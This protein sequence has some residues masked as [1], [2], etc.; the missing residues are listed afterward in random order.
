MPQ[1]ML[2][3]SLL[4][5]AGVNFVDVLSKSGQWGAIRLVYN[6]PPITTEQIFHPEKY[7]TGEAP[8]PVDLPNLAPALGQ[9]WVEINNGVL[10]E[11]FLR[12][13]LG[14]FAGLGLDNA[15]TGWGGDRFSLLEGPEEDRTFTA[16]I[17]WDSDR[18]A[19]E[20]YEFV[21]SNSMDSEDVFFRKK[22]EQVLW[23]VGKPP[24]ILKIRSQF[25]DFEQ[26][27]SGL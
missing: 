9:G 14:E 24:L 12:A 6:N 18:D 17:E 5:Q 13:Y 11:S 3:L 16:L 25:P 2:R 20:F 22:G 10:G 4:S 26:E 23:I 19:E 15:A 8:V 1:F 21:I 7:I 27:S